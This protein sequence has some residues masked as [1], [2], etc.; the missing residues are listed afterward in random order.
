MATLILTAVGTALG[1]PVGGLLGALAGQAVDQR[2]FAPKARQGPRLTDLKLQTSTYGS[3]LPKL[4]G[5]TRVAGTVIWS[6]DLI[7]KRGSQSNGKERPRTQTYSYSA[8]FAVALSARPIIRVERIWADGK[9]LRGAAGD[10]K[11]ETGFR[12]HNGSEDQALDPLIASA[13]GNALTPA[14]RG[15]AYV[16]FDKMALGDYGNRIPSLSF[17]VVADETPKRAGSILVELAGS[18]ASTA[19]GP[20]LLGLAAQGDSVRG[21][22]EAIGAA[23][24]FTVIDGAHLAFDPRPAREVFTE[25]LGAGGGERLAVDRRAIAQT[26]ETLVLTYLDWSRDYQEGTQQASRGGGGRREVR[27]DLAAVLEASTAKQIVEA[28]SRAFEAERTALRFAIPWR[29]LELSPGD[30]VRLDGVQGAFRVRRVSFEA[31]TLKAECVRTATKPAASVADPGSGVSE[32]DR[33]HGPTRLLIADLPQLRDEASTV[34]MLAVAANGTLP[35]WRRA[36]LLASGDGGQ[37]YRELGETALPATLG[38]TDTVLSDGYAALVDMVASLDVRLAHPELSLFDADMPQLL[39]GANSALVGDEVLQFA[40][41]E[42]L[43]ARLWRLTGLWRGRRGTEWA[44]ARHVAAEPFVVLSE[45]TLFFV[46]ADR[47]SAGM[48]VTALGVGDV[49]GV[50]MIAPDMVGRALRPLSPCKLRLRLAGSDTILTWTRR[51]RDGWNWRDGADA[52][53]AEEREVY[54]VTKRLSTGATSSVEVN[55]Q[56][57]TYGADMRATD[58]AAGALNAVFSI[59]QVGTFGASR[60]VTVALALI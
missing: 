19:G 14:Y 2:V 52:P 21:V 4:F 39:S 41:A 17:E 35:G 20:E 16:V 54:R 18:G 1:G 23:T 5:R 11:T 48:R 45:E 34:P 42:R 25:D 50:E 46:P 15:L 57:W 6:T 27:I 31:M 3:P 9:L 43:D 51:S 60:P 53:L 40:R 29:G 59:E 12:V 55:V 32:Q 44:M 26:V 47:I 22:A 58:V 10:F 7:E 28:R 13:E 33:A 56:E 38:T 49:D 30:H 8:S 37:S 24:P 36:A